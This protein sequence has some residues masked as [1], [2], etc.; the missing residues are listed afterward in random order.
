M[1]LPLLLSLANASNV[2]LYDKYTNS[3]I[4]NLANWTPHLESCNKVPDENFNLIAGKFSFPRYDVLVEILGPSDAYL[5]R[6]GQLIHHNNFR[7]LVLLD[8]VTNMSLDRVRKT[9]YWMKD[10]I[11]WSWGGFVTRLPSNVVD[12]EVTNGD[13]IMMKEDN[14]FMLNN[15]PIDRVKSDRIC[16]FPRPRENVEAFYEYFVIPLL[17]VV[18]L[19]CYLLVRSRSPALA[20]KTRKLVAECLDGPLRKAASPASSPSMELSTRARS[21][22]SPAS[23]RSSPTRGF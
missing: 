15:E 20:K 23:A 5:W 12:F 21:P 14:S 19:P 3:P 8:N 13:V 4:E 9:L 18:C 2:T 1:W 17:M 16:F 22:E 6:G 10:D 7:E 11:P